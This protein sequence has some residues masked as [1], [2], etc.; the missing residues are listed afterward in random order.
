MLTY[1]STPANSGGFTPVM[2]GS[3]GYVNQSQGYTY[4]Y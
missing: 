2:P 1:N 3:A 4:F